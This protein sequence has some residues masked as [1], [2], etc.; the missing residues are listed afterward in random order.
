MKWNFIINHNGCLLAADY[1]G[2]A[3]KRLL[4]TTEKYNETPK[5]LML[6]NVKN[7]VGKIYHCKY[8]TINI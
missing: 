2:A 1:P 8:L 4:E 6:E 5:Y 7:L 3:I